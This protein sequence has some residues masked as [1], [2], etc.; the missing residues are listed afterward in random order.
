M[1]EGR[2]KGKIVVFGILF[3]YPLAGVTYQ[4]L[5][6]LL[7]LRRLG[8]D[9]YYVEDSGRY[10]YDPA[11]NDLSDDPSA[12]L[13]SV[14]PVLEAHGFSRRWAF[15]GAYPGGGCY[16]LTE[17]ELLQLYRDAD[18]MLNVTGAQEIRPEHLTFKRRIYVETDPVASQIRVANGDEETISALR[19]HDTHF[20]FG[21]N[22]GAPDCGVPPGGFH[23]LPTRQPVALDLWPPAPAAP[24][25]A[26]TTIATWQNTGK[27]VTYEGETY[28]WSKHHEFLKVIDLPGRSA[29]A[30]ELAAR[31]PDSVRQLLVGNGWRHRD[32][33]AL[34]RDI[35]SYRS[36]IQ[37]SRGEF[38]VA[39]DQNVRLRSGWF[40]DRSACYLAAG[41]PVITQDTGFSHVLPTGR[42]LFAFRD[43][44]DILAAVD[45]IESDYELHCRAAREIAA[46][47]FEAEKVVGSLMSRA[48]L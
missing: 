8:Y 29:A 34:S 10:V 23:W 7:A 22:L 45:A 33:L 12:N 20:T 9:P 11:R 36:Y 21:E 37:A 46:E 16:G 35:E 48:A 40:S 47:Y 19:A 41:R 5:H 14:V 3:W 6:Y 39:K 27:D 30:F 2:S 42:G 1:A 4:F 43:T 38:T 17:S 18:A 25:S 28:S 13:L 32:S 15:R 31:V 44:A 26:Y 24:E